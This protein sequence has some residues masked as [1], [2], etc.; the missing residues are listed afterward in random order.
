MS[1]AFRKTAKGQA[2]VETRA[3]RLS[4]RLRALLIMVDGKRDLAALSTV[5]PPSA[6]AAL[7]EL[8]AQGFVEPVAAAAAPTAPVPSPA[9]AAGVAGPTRSASTP[10]AGLD[11][12]R[13]DA[14]RALNEAAGPAAEAL[15]VRM[16]KARGAEELRPLI[17]LAART[18]AN[19]RGRAAGEAYAER[20]NV[21]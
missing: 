9:V 1:V 21:D 8:W 10:A 19:L 18:V 4:P 6:Q 3:H 15:A 11:T 20:F 2:E 16:E 5:A 12:L 17:A 7:D 13:R 14:V